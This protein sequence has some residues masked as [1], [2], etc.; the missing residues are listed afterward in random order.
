[1][2]KAS[3]L[4]LLVQLSRPFFKPADEHHLVI[5]FE[6]ITFFHDVQLSSKKI[7]ILYQITQ[8]P[9]PQ[10]ISSAAVKISVTDISPISSP[11][12][13]ATGMWWMLCACMRLEQSLSVQSG[14]AVITGAV[15]I[16]R[17]RTSAG[18]RSGAMILSRISVLVRMPYV[19]L[20]SVI[21]TTTL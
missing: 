8:L 21:L 3:D 2:K 1:M 17:T 9:F 14:L 19:R 11:A 15:M 18:L 13:S 12:S 5:H 10:P 7:E 20:S 4:A 6:I 16:S